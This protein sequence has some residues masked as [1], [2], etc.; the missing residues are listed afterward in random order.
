MRDALQF[1]LNIPSVKAMALNSPDHVF[2]K[3]K[4]F[5]MTF[6]KDTTDA[7]LALALG[8]AETRPID[9]VGAYS[10]LANGGVKVEQTSILNIKDASGNDVKLPDRGRPGAGRQAA[11]GVH[12]HGHPQRQHQSSDQPVLGQVPDHAARTAPVDPRRS[13]PAPTTTR[14]TSTPTGTSRRRPKRAE[15]PARTRLLSGSGTAT[16]T[17]RRCRRRI[18]RSSRS[19]SPRTSGRDSCR[20]RARNG[21]SRA[22]DVPKAG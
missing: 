16:A 1:S 21:R 17:T 12:H 19:T 10:T 5:G 6:Q 8:V 14:R 22:S 13:R 20:T 15:R 4:D 2:A 11:I 3:A 9:L 7:G 18:A